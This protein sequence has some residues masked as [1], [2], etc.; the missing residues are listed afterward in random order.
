MGNLPE[1]RV[2][3]FGRPFEKYEVNYAGPMYYK[4]EQRKNSR[5]IKCFIAIFV[6]FTTKTLH[7][8]LVGNLNTEAFLSKKCA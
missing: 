8:E 7:I 3:I 4:E 6:Y 1:S 2:S 5:S